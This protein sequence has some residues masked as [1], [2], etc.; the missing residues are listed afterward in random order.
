MADNNEVVILGAGFSSPAKIPLQDRILEEMTRIPDGILSYSSVRESNKFL[1]AF[2]NVGIYLLQNYSVVDC[3]KYAREYSLWKT[4]RKYRKLHGDE[5]KD[6]TVELG[7]LLALQENVR[8]EMEAS[9]IGISLEDVFTSFDIISRNRDFFHDYSPQEVE[10]IKESIKRLFVFYFSK[11]CRDHLY[12]DDNYINFCSYIKK[13]ED[14]SII[15]TN[16]DVL[17]E[18]YFNRQRIKYEL[19]FN[20]RYYS[21]TE[22]KQHKSSKIKYIKIHGSINWFRCMKCGKINISNIDQCGD[23]LFDDSRS[24]KCSSCKQVSS[25]SQ[26]L[27]PQ[28]ITPTMMKS[29]GNQLF[30]NLWASAREQLSRAKHVIFVGYSMPIADFDFRYLLHQT[31]SKK[32]KIDVVLYHDDNPHGISDKKIKNLLPE[33]RYRDLFASNDIHFYYNGFGEFFKKV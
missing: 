21:W 28:I 4:E 6:K 26:I 14:P 8:R 20:D 32:A 7:V 10:D 23:Y 18:E 11:H 24:E 13:M 5:Y 3:S 33:K 27:Q 25:D 29:F 9:N 2:I 15:S 17:L 16:W 22:E 1:E 31:V 19:C 30:I 12:L